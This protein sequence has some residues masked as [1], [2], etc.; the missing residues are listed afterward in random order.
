MNDDMNKFESRDEL[1][2]RYLDGEL[3][4]E[5][6]R[7]VLHLIA[8]D[9]E[10]RE[11]LRFERSVVL[12]FADIQDPGSF[13]VPEHFGS[14]VM[15]RIVKTN[16]ESAV[17]ENKQAPVFS[18]LKNRT[19]TINPA[20]AAAAMFL[21]TF[22]FGYL[23]LNPAT[24]AVD[25]TETLTSQAQIQSVSDSGGESQI[26]I[27]FVYFDETAESI[28][29]A[30]DFNNWEPTELTLEFMGDRQ[31]WTG[32]IPLTR[33][34]HSYMF[35]RNGEEWVTDPLAEVQKDD[36]FGNKNAVLYL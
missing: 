19:I 2:R 18:L 12:S 13:T 3:S 14:S 7:E 31:V 15:D 10:M 32:L 23:L 11:I 16:R 29:I 6:E 17:A 9:E 34:E 33:G 28:E 25:D 36:G 21:I 30:G 35:V 8:D 26:W 20:L 4:S 24:S 1:F 27:R 22:G 5:E